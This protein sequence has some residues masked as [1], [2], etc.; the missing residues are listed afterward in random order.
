MP[1]RLVMLGM[2]HVHAPGLAQQIAAHPDEFELCGVW[3]PDP[4]VSERR[5]IEWSSLFPGLRV[6][7]RPADLLDQ[8]LDG[9]VVEGMISENLS[10]ARMA[11]ERNL[12]VLLEKP[13]GCKLDEMR[14]VYELARRKN[15]HLQ[16]IYL[17]RY[18]SAV[19]EML[20]RARRGDLGHIYEFRG[21]LPKDLRLYDEHVATLGRYRGGIFFEMAGHLIDFMCALLGPPREVKSIVGHYHPTQ[22]A[23]STN[24]FIDTGT[25][26]FG[27]ER[28]VGIVE[29]PALEVTPD[30][31]RVEVYGTEGALIIPHLGSGHLTNEAMQPLD[32]LARGASTW[33]R[34]PLP[35]A[36][37]QI[38]DLR[39]FVAVASGRKTPD[40][41]LDHD[42]A[43]Q[44][45]LLTAC[46]MV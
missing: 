5:R 32:I 25:A 6:F 38:R 18:M 15:L 20:K 35:Q 14:D 16:L 3:D 13:A 44:T 33:E 28:A 36:T 7:A 22:S 39:E 31:R 23:A 2:W 40:Y 11:L 1:F 21:R 26:I 19:E 37:L 17:F 9:V 34:L 27:F 43:V 12:P 10:Y 30:Q 24:D 45:A 42:L 46:E 4:V 8:Q 41:S 29:V